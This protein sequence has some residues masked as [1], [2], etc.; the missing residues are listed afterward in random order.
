MHWLLCAVYCEKQQVT[1]VDSLAHNSEHEFQELRGYGETVLRY[2][3]YLVCSY[4]RFNS[5][6]LSVTP[7]WQLAYISRNMVMKWLRLFFP[8]QLPS[9]RVLEC[10]QVGAARNVAGGR[11]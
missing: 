2:L 11:L 9:G 3:D 8:L 1:I 10:A 7:S 6:C 4:V 5:S